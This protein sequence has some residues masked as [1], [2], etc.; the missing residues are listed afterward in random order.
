LKNKKLLGLN[1]QLRDEFRGI[2]TIDLRNASPSALLFTVWEFSC[3][4]GAISHRKALAPGLQRCLVAL[5]RL[6][7]QV[8]NARLATAVT[9][10]PL[11]RLTR[12][13]WLRIVRDGVWA[14]HRRAAGS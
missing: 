1:P 5:Q 3:S 2:V 4:G 6:P 10:L 7:V 14:T 12:R 11:F 8:I 9:T 13:L